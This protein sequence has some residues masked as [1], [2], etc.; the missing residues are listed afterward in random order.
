MLLRALEEKT[1]LPF[2]SDREAHSDFQLI[3][4]TNR[5]LP[6]AVRSG[7]FRE[8]LLCR[9]NLWTFTLPGLRSRPEDIEPNLQFELDQFAERTGRRVTISREARERFLESALAPS[10][11][12][13][14][15]FRDLNAAVTR[16]A[17][18]AQGGRIS[19]EIVREEIARV[20]AGWTALEQQESSGALL[21]E[22]LNDQALAEIDLFDRVQLAHVLQICRE[23]RSIS[24]AGR[25]LFDASRT[26]KTSSNDADRLR[27]YLHRFHLEWSQ[28]SASNSKS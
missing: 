1:F 14:G 24:E 12:W 6:A 10:A 25:R 3:A 17:T 7:R 5:D 9:I 23:S 11:G 18:L 19:V 26:R 22:Y 16:M 20:A 15:N 28:I 4:G 13:N 8:D 27:K 21:S 2:G